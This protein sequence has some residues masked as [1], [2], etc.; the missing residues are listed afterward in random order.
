MFEH[1]QLKLSHPMGSYE[2]SIPTKS[3]SYNV[4]LLWKSLACVSYVRTYSRAA[5]G[6][7]HLSTACFAAIHNKMGG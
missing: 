4:S 3:P 7:V 2:G 5:S 6:V 1:M